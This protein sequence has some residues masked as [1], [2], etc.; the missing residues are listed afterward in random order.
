LIYSVCCIPLVYV[1]IGIPLLLAL[2]LASF[3]CAIIAAIKASEG[4]F[5][6]YPLTIRFI[7]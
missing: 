6:F 5:Y 3:I 2:G 4:A 7:T 1:C